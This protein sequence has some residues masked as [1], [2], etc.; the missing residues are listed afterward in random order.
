MNSLGDKRSEDVAY[1]LEELRLYEGQSTR[2]TES[3]ERQNK[4]N[5]KIE[6]DL[7]R[8]INENINTASCLS[9]SIS[10]LTNAGEEEHTN[11]LSGL[12]DEIEAAY[13][14]LQATQKNE[15]L[16][17]T[18]LARIAAY[19]LSNDKNYYSHINVLTTTIQCFYQILG[20]CEEHNGRLKTKLKVGLGE[21]FFGEK[22]LIP[23][24]TRPQFSA[25]KKKMAPHYVEATRIAALL[26][27]YLAEV[28][29]LLQKK[30]EI[31]L[32]R[33][34]QLEDSHGAAKAQL[35]K[36][37]TLLKDVYRA[38][39]GA[40]KTIQKLQ[41]MNEDKKKTR[42]ELQRE[43]MKLERILKQS[44][45]SAAKEETIGRSSKEIEMLKQ[46]LEEVFQ[47]SQKAHVEEGDA[48][49]VVQLETAALERAHSVLSHL[50]EEISTLEREKFDFQEQLETSHVMQQEQVWESENEERKRELYEERNK[51]EVAQKLF[52]E[53]V[54]LFTASLNEARKR[55]EM[56]KAQLELKMN[57]RSMLC[58]E[59]VLIEEIIKKT[60]TDCVC[61]CNVI[62]ETRKSILELEKQDAEVLEKLR[63]INSLGFDTT[64][65]TSPTLL[66]DSQEACSSPVDENLREMLVLQKKSLLARARKEHRHN[67][68][69]TNA[70]SI[71]KT[72]FNRQGST[73]GESKEGGQNSVAL[74]TTEQ[75]LSFTNTLT[76]AAHALTLSSND[77]DHH[78]LV[79]GQGRE[80]ASLLMPIEKQPTS[81]RSRILGPLNKNFFPN[82]PISASAPDTRW[83]SGLSGGDVSGLLATDMKTT[84][85]SPEILTG[86]NEEDSVKGT[87]TIAH[88]NLRLQEI[89]GRRY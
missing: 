26:P 44:E 65:L 37:G 19:V 4:E 29:I 72:G 50:E 38:V 84:T 78:H 12:Q 40:E 55:M 25:T 56:M 74:T 63:Y 6:A 88:I 69:T 30:E 15:E 71:S 66:I 27:K 62:I 81:V 83:R 17:G 47:L 89:L 8:L 60:K 54:G 3:L 20:I 85:P 41:A 68:A 64:F 23:E 24:E 75:P 32:S 58:D 53:E 13:Q 77:D 86:L 31:F 21:T 73:I 22:L 2:L 16:T 1:W 46:N 57:R 51:I 7:M 10:T 76:H 39:D 9:T 11:A 5:A 59:K 45:R 35:V 14:T 18:A 28:I 87:P 67:G 49:K 80:R 82:I 34:K 70:S 48:K 42:D 36:Q 52:E 33:R 79:V 61:S 43:L